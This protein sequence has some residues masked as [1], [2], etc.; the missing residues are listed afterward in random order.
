M[1]PESING[2]AIFSN[3]DQTRKYLDLIIYILGRLSSPD[4][5]KE[6]C[7]D[8]LSSLKKMLQFEAIGLRIKSGADY[9]YFVTQGFP[10]HFIEAERF[11]CSTDPNGMFI[12]DSDGIPQLECMCGTVISGRTDPSRSFFTPYGSFW[13]NSTTK[14][15]A[16]TSEEQRQ[17]RT[18]NR[19]NSEGYESVALIPL[20]STDDTLGLLQLNDRNKDMFTPMMIS[21]IEGV[22]NIIGIGLN[23]RGHNNRVFG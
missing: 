13:S 8:I 20:R 12:T 9:P 15:L 11:L 18:R 2:K 17:G 19:C 10:E 3:L 14:L 23:Q 7:S 22:A 5:D 6:V 4:E 1:A 21:V 16:E